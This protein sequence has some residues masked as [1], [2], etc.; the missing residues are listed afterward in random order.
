M[1][2]ASHCGW[3]EHAH[4]LAR[5]GELLSHV[6]VL[7][8]HLGLC[9]QC[10]PEVSEQLEARYER[11]GDIVSSDDWIIDLSEDSLVVEEN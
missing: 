3:K 7:M 6:C 11:L 1:Y 8:A 9:K 4:A 2:A 10:R 5:G